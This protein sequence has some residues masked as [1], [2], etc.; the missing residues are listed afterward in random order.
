VLAT[1]YD[2]TTT[3]TFA[4]DTVYF[5]I[6]QKAYALNA[7]VLPGTYYEGQ[8]AIEKWTVTVGGYPT[9]PTVADGKVFLSNDYNTPLLGRSHRNNIMDL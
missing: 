6:G 9:S 7:N 5:A 4:D 8:I 1:Q 2:I 3:P